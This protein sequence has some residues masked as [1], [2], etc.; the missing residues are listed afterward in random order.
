MPHGG[1][2]IANVAGAVAETLAQVAPRTRSTPSAVAANSGAPEPGLRVAVHDRSR[3]EWV[4]TVPIA[5]VGEDHTW[6]ITFDI[7]VPDAIWLAHHPWDHFTVRSRLMSPV[8]MP[9]N[10][11]VGLPVEQLRRLALAAAHE[12]K[13]ATETIGAKLL[14]IRKRD[15]LVGDR[16]ADELVAA[17]ER[18]TAGAVRARDNLDQ[19]RSHADEPLLRELGL[20]DEFISNQLLMLVTKVVRTLG[21]LR[22]RTGRI[23]PALAGPGADR[24]QATIHAVMGREIAHRKRHAM[25][26]ADPRKP[27]D[28]EGFVQRGALLKKHFQQALFLDARAYMLDQRLRN[29]IAAA[30]AMVASVFYFVGQIWLF[31]NATAASTTFSL[32]AAC[33]IGALVYAAKDR[34]KELGRDWLA[35][36]VKHGYADRVAHLSLQARMDPNHS[37]FALARE[38]I[39][40]TRKLAPDPLNAA[41]GN[42][43]VV[44]HLTIKERL[45]HDG[46]PILHQQGLVGLKHVFRYDLSPL[47]VKLDDQRK[48]VPVLA[49]Q[50]VQL[51]TATRVYGLPVT[52]RLHKV[53]TEFAMTHHGHLRVRR[54][55]LERVVLQNAKE[56]T[57]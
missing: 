26:F 56:P 15:R 54:D 10:R 44:H 30:M 45:K 33:G 55:G 37:D 16:E 6:D 50:R 32:L 13:L 18:A 48:R 4:A 41:L 46:L 36:R 5:P 20:A 31:N 9:G 22:A 3:I 29:W 51:R 21:P 42:T 38:T 14:A 24:V 34:I 39:T 25:R 47:L 11:Q 8:L 35:R 43:S 49:R 53:G 57:S 40:L 17:I 52:V 28:V 23:D 1:R 12:L 7:T 27:A 19:L 2:M